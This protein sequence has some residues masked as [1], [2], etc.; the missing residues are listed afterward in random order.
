MK[1]TTRGSGCRK[2]D[3]PPTL[4]SKEVGVRPAQGGN[5]RHLAGS[6][7][8]SARPVTGPGGTLVGV[9]IIKNFTD[10][11][12]IAVVNDVAYVNRGSDIDGNDVERVVR[13]LIANC[14]GKVKIACH[15]KAA[16][17][18]LGNRFT[19]AQLE[20][21]LETY[22]PC[23]RSGWTDFKKKAGGMT[24]PY[25]SLVAVD[26]PKPKTKAKPKLGGTKLVD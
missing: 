2:Q 25:L 7:D 1:R 12:S 11:V 18:D 24:T 10:T 14:V 22:E 3:F 6:H 13:N 26:Q 16:G 5:G 23:L 17:P 21:L 15:T 4:I 8:L 19:P 20:T 9:K